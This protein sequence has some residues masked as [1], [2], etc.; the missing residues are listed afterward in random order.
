M[1]LMVVGVPS[2]KLNTGRPRWL[3]TSFKRLLT[4]CTERVQSL[5]HHLKMLAGLEVH[6][7][8]SWRS[9]HVAQVPPNVGQVAAQVWTGIEDQ[10]RGGSSQLAVTEVHEDTHEG[11]HDG[12]HIARLQKVLGQE[13]G[14]I[15]HREQAS[16]RDVLRQPGGG[17]AV[18]MVQ[19]ARLVPRLHVVNPLPAPGGKGTTPDAMNKYHIHYRSSCMPTFKQHL[20]GVRKGRHYNKHGQ[21][22]TIE[23]V[24]QDI[25]LVTLELARM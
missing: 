19:V 18:E 6:N 20:C 14:C 3:Q 16:L 22:Q 12:M 1:L 21:V 7:R 23:A 13:W 15:F 17:P 11:V 2:P 5:R 9:S 4:S 10:A 8:G 25:I 24:A